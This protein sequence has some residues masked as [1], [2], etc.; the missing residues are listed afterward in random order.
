MLYRTTLAASLLST[1]AFAGS[2]GT[3]NFGNTITGSDVNSSV[4]SDLFFDISDTASELVR[5][6][7]AAAN[8]IDLGMTFSFYGQDY[9]ALTFAAPGYISTS[10]TD[11]GNDL[12]NDPLLPD[13]PSAGDGGR[14]YTHHD[15]VESVIYG[16]FFSADNNPFGVDAYIAQYDSCHFNCTPGTDV[17]IQYNVALLSDGTIIIAHNLASDEEGYS[18]T[19]GIQ[20]EIFADGI[21]YTADEAGGIV[22]GQTV[23][24]IPPESGLST[25]VRNLATE[26]GIAEITVLSES[27]HGHLATSGPDSFATQA[28]KAPE[29][30]FDIFGK[31]ARYQPWVN[32]QVLHSTTGDAAS[33]E[34]TALYVQGG[35][36]LH[37]TDRFAAGIGL[38]FSRGTGT[39][40]AASA[41]LR[42]EIF[43]LYGETALKD[44]AIGS[45][46]SYGRA[47]YDDLE[48]TFLDNI[49]AEGERSLFSLSVTKDFAISNDLTISPRLTAIAGRERISDWDAGDGVSR[50]V[51]ESLFRKTELTGKISRQ[52]NSLR[53]GTGFLVAGA[54]YLTIDG[55]SDN[56]L[57]T[58]GYESERAG[59]VAGI[60]VEELAIGNMTLSVDLTA[61]GI[62][63]DSYTLN[64]GLTLEF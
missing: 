59:G 46:L 48:T 55:D 64:G 16:A 28:A 51:E 10:A 56:V 12:S 15:D 39:F 41:D 61:S 27:A 4:K 3:D 13:R 6:S 2:T 50:S 47:H 9:T 7:L 37:R 58:V 23:V 57:F 36:D 32:A 19:L 17:T 60:G 22:D 53:G 29:E 44:W 11:I 14:I 31:A 42:S 33:V 8:G 49:N 1:T 52:F 20:D 34:T 5:G 54:D 62:T 45:T 35:V 63:Q 26:A 38:G 24:V 43:F 21:A 18:A 30:G 40:G 25:D